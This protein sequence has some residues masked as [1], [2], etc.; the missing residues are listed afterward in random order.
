MTA[1]AID[2][3]QEDFPTVTFSPKINTGSS[4]GTKHTTVI[5]KVSGGSPVTSGLGGDPHFYSRSSPTVFKYTYIGEDQNTGKA[6]DMKVKL[7]DLSSRITMVGYKKD[8]GISINMNGGGR[9]GRTM[10]VQLSFYY[11]GTNTQ[12][13][14]NDDSIGVAFSD[15]EP[16]KLAADG[17]IQQS[18]GQYVKKISD[19][20]S[21]N[22]YSDLTGKQTFLN[23]HDANQGYFHMDKDSGTWDFPTKAYLDNKD[24]KTGKTWGYNPSSGIEIE[25]PQVHQYIHSFWTYPAATNRDLRAGLHYTGAIAVYKA[26]SGAKTIS[27]LVGGHSQGNDEFILSDANI[28]VSNKKKKSTISKSITYN[29]K[30]STANTLKDKN[31]TMVYNVNA[32][33]SAKKGAYI[34]D[35]L[36]KRFTVTKIS[37][38]TNFSHNSVADVNST[39][40]F[41]ATL[42]NNKLDGKNKKITFH[43]TG[44][45]GT[46][47]DKHPSMVA[48]LKWPVVNTAYGYPKSTGKLKSSGSRHY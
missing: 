47:M 21:W 29:G 18:F 30:T 33:V 25:R 31:D 13:K 16:E 15:L 24:K 8:H 26:A 6:V 46:W 1:K 45:M 20:D 27:F 11:H 40:K 19:V 44:N 48:S 38:V 7:Y 35:T 39:H 43:I 17:V 32:T 41:K 22:P 36:P 23:N 10:K 12:V 9:A 28:K 42:N 14:W 37:A 5:T 3:H 4:N 2:G 34:T